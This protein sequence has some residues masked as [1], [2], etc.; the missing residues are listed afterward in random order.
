M[1]KMA[2]TPIYGKKTSK[3]F[4]QT[5]GSIGTWYIA[6]GMRV[7]HNLYTQISTLADREIF[8]A[9]VKFGGWR[10]VK[11][12]FRKVLQPILSKLADSLN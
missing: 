7:H 12:I 11:I 3:F 2:A 4:S 1:T 6:L 10:Y 5:S 8:Y 9:K